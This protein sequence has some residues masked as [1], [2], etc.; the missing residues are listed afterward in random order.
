[1]PRSDTDESRGPSVAFLEGVASRQGALQIP[2][3]GRD[4]K[5]RVVTH[6]GV[7]EAD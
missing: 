5:G 1:M 4:D 2:S 6:L 7:C 3:V